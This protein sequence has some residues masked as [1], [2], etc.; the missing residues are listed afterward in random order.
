MISK[1]FMAGAAVAWLMIFI[2]D[3]LL[4]GLMVHNAFKTRKEL[5][6][7]HRLKFRASLRVILLR[8]GM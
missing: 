6:M 2:Y 8:D 7:I 1:I 5:H 3:V 4:F